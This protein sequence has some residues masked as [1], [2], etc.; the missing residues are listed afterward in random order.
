[1]TLS[2][3]TQFE[4]R[5]YFFI[6][7]F[8]YVCGRTCHLD[9]DPWVFY[10]TLVVPLYQTSLNRILWFIDLYSIIHRFS[11]SFEGAVETQTNQCY[12]FSIQMSGSGEL[13][14]YW[15]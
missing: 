12:S 2:G 11:F 15:S 10:V 3:V 5:G 6:C 7:L 13:I 1:M 8:I 4:N 14:R 9:F